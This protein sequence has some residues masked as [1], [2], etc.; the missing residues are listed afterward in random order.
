M[1]RSAPHPKGRIVRRAA[2]WILACAVGCLVVT[3]C[4][5]SGG[6]EATRRPLAVFAAASFSTAFAE[7]EDAYETATPDVDVRLNLAGS[8]ALRV[9]ILEGAPADVYASADE[10]NMNEILAADAATTSMVF[11]RNTMQLAVPAGNPAQVSGLSDLADDDLLIGLC[12]EGVPCGEFA[13]QVLAN[14]GITPAPDTNEADVRSL[15]TKIGTGELDAGIVYASDIVD[16]PNL[17]GVEIDAAVNVVT[18]APGAVLA[19]SSM[20]VEA[21]AFLEFMLSSAGRAILAQNGFAT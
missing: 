7:V 1:A 8:S 19:E 13:R 21:A 2:R 4:S 16:V 14:A 20:P 17:E 6:D 12:A 18:V 3:A 10:S 15:L 5:A 11:A 9:Q